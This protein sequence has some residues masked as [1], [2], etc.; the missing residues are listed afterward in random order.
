MSVIKYRFSNIDQS[1]LHFVPLS[2]EYVT[3]AALQCPR[4]T[5]TFGRRQM[6][7]IR[8]N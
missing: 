1:A 6:H 3:S 8:N 4:H 7:Y 2:P 5:D